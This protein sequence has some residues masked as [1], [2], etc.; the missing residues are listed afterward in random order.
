MKPYYC[1]PHILGAQFETYFCQMNQH[2]KFKDNTYIHSYTVQIRMHWFTHWD[3]IHAKFKIQSR[4]SDG[5]KLT[6]LHMW[7]NIFQGGS[8]FHI[9]FFKQTP[10]SLKV[11]HSKWPSIYSWFIY[12][13]VGGFSS[14]LFVCLPE[15]TWD[16]GILVE[17]YSYFWDGLKLKL[18]KTTIY[19]YLGWDDSYFWDGLKLL[20]TTLKSFRCHRQGLSTVGWLWERNGLQ[21][22]FQAAIMWTALHFCQT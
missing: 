18:L 17:K 22:L 10:G 3:A 6:G 4:N 16:M 15:A 21:R 19:G 2:Q 13:K 5:K 14:S 12:E 1:R 11:C 8:L 7:T 20:K 9:L